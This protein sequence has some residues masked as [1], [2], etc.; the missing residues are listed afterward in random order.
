MQQQADLKD[1]LPTKLQTEIEPQL[2]LLNPLLTHTVEVKN[3]FPVVNID[4]AHV[5]FDVSIRPNVKSTLKCKIKTMVMGEDNSHVQTIIINN[6]DVTVLRFVI[7]I[8]ETE[9]AA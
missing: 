7:G 2:R 8:D 9:D 3:I 1:I 4:H 5:S 6:S